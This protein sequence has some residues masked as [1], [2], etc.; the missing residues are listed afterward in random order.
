MVREL[1][2]EHSH[3][4]PSQ[5]PRPA[6]GPHI[7]PGCVQHWSFSCSFWLNKQVRG[8]GEGGSQG[9]VFGGRGRKVGSG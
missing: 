4:V 8:S 6:R 5:R 2:A 1:F 9:H 7:L 3:T